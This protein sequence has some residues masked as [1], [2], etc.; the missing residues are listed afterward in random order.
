[1]S[2]IT[3]PSEPDLGRMQRDRSARLQAVMADQGVD[4][5]V[6]LGN[7]NVSY[8]TGARWPLSDPGRAN[9]ERPV[10]VVTAG[11][12]LPHVFTPFPEGA[13]DLDLPDDHLHGPVYLD[14]GEGA[15]AFAGILGDLVPDVGRVAVD[16]L[17]GSMQRAQKLLFPDGPPTSAD[18]VIGTAKLTKTPDELGFLRIA[19][20]ITEE[21][22]A[23]V[24]AALA[25]GVRQTD[26]TAHFLHQVFELGADANILDPIW[27]VMPDRME[28]GPWTT[29]GDI[30]CPLL[31]TER[32]LVEG[33]VIWVDT[34]VSYAGFSSDFGR[35]W[36]VGRDPTPRQ[37]AQFRGWRQIIDAVLEVTR[38][39]A[40]GA[41]LTSAAL[42]ACDGRRPWMQHFYLGHGLGIESAESPFIGTDLGDAYDAR[43]VLSAG[44]VL[45]LEPLI[46]DEGASGYR[47][48]E[49]IVVTDDGWISL[50]DYPYDPYG[51]PHGD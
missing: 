26:L 37:H 34:G 18:D 46:W 7:S 2:T 44:T 25:P 42:A 9:V 45:V 49:V 23:T 32:E 1:M 27:Q 30:A 13:D 8:A 4:T 12:P 38:A 16:E 36:V 5:L 48:E 51:Y 3:I 33:D 21:A 11:D 14:F 24:Q 40:T 35:T 22:I 31:T 20:R 50:T 10:A 15:E 19:L 47:A 29:H 39:G 41:D 43:Q 28:D 17:P 6:L